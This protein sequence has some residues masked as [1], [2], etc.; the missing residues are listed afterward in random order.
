VPHP[1][2][3]LDWNRLLNGQ[4]PMVQA[5][6]PAQA[7][8]TTQAAP[9]QSL[10]ARV[11]NLFKSFFGTQQLS[12]QQDFFELGGDSLKAM[13]LLGRIK[14]VFE[15]EMTLPQFF[16]NTQLESLYRHIE[17][18]SAP[19]IQ[20][21]T[22]AATQSSYPLTPAQQHMWLLC[23]EPQANVAYNL[24]AVYTL[25][26][27]VQLPLLQQALQ[28]VVQRHEV[29]RTI[30]RA[31]E[32][33]EDAVRQVVL[34]KPT[35]KVQVLKPGSQTTAQT[36]QAF[37]TQP[38]DLAQG[39]LIRL[40][41]L[42]NGPEQHLVLLCAHHLVSDGQSIE[43]IQQELIQAYQA[44]QQK[45]P[46]DLAPLPLQFK[47]YAT[48]LHHAL[49]EK[50]RLQQAKN[51]WTQQFEQPVPALNLVTDHPRPALNTYQGSFVNHY[52][53]AA[54]VP[55][56]KQL[57][58]EQGVSMFMGLMAATYTLLYKYTGQTDVVI[59]SP[60]TG[61]S[62]P[63][64]Q[65]QVGYYV[66]MLPVRA[67]VAPHQP[68][69]QLLQQVKQAC[70][71]A[72]A[73]QDFPLESLMAQLAQQHEGQRNTL[74][75]ISLL[76]N[77]TAQDPTPV[78]HA[79][80]D[81]QQA[82]TT[83]KF[84]L[85]FN[86]IEG[87][88]S[89]QIQLE[90]STD[91][92]ERQTVQMLAQHLAYLLQQ[93]PQQQQQSPQDISLVSKEEQHQLLHTF[94]N[95]TEQYPAKSSIAAQFEAQA[96]S[97]PNATALTFEQ[98]SLSYQQL[99]AQA[100]QLAAC[101]LQQHQLKKG[102]AVAI[103]LERG[104]SLIV[105]T[106]A[107]LKAG[108][109]YVPIDTAHPTQRQ[110][111]LLQNSGAVLHINAAFYQAFA[112]QQEQWPS[113]NPKVQVHGQDLA[114]IMYTSGS[115]GN[116]KGVMVEQHSVL[117]LVKGQNYMPLN[118]STTLLSTGAVAFDAVVF[119]YWG[120]LLNG[121]HLIMCTAEAL[122][123]P[124]WL[125]QLVQQHQVNTFWLTTG[126]LN[127]LTESVPELFKG[128]Q[129]LIF[130]GER[131]SAPHVH[132]L[133]EL[134]PEM[135][136]IQAYGPTENT[137]Y[138]HTCRLLPH[139]GQRLPLGQPISNTTAY[140]LDA[141]DRLQPIGVPGQICLGGAGL[142]RGYLNQPALTQK[143]FVP[144]PFAPG[145]KM[146][147]TGDV[148]RM[149]PNGQLLFIGRKDNQIK[150]RGHRIELGEIERVLEQH[151]QV[152]QNVVLAQSLPQK[153]H[154]TLVAYVALQ[155]N[156]N[157]QPQELQSYLANALPAYMVPEHVL[158]LPKL[159]LNQNGKINRKALPPVQEQTPQQEA[160]TAPETTTQ[161][162]L[163]ALWAQVL[164]INPQ[165]VGQSQ[166][167]FDLGGHSLSVLRLISLIQKE[168]QL[169]LSVKSIFENPTLA[170]QAQHLD[171]QQAQ[172]F[173]QIPVAPT[174][175]SYVLSAAQQRLWVLCQFEQANAA[176]NIPSLHLLQGK[177]NT[178]AL[179]QAFK[180]LIDRHA[181]L[182]TVFKEVQPE[183]VHQVVQAQ[184][185]FALHQQDL[186]QQ[187]PTQAQNT[188]NGFA[189]QPFNLA[190][191]P[192]LR[193]GLFK[194]APQK[195]VLVIVLHHI[196][197]DGASMQVFFK[198]LMHLYNGHEPLPPLRIQYHDYAVW[199]QQQGQQGALQQAKA[200][201]LEQFA[202]PLPVLEIPANKPRP[203]VKTYQGGTVQL[204]LNAKAVQ[205]LKA[206]CQ[207][208]EAT[209]FMGLYALTN[210]LLYRYSGQTD[211]VLGS[212]VAG[213]EHVDLQE[214]I[215]FYV[216]MLPLRL[217]LEQEQSFE[218]VLAQARQVLLN[219]Y[220]HQSYPFDALVQA[221]DPP[222]NPSRSPLF[223]VM[224]TFQ[225][226]E[227]TPAQ[228]ATG[229]LQATPY[230]QAFEYQVSKYDLVFNYAHNGQQVGLGL[231]YNSNLFNRATI[232]HMATHLEQLL[233]SLAKQPAQSIAAAN[234]LTPPQRQE[235]LQDFNNTQ[236]PF[237]HHK[238]LVHRF[239][240]QAA[241]R[242]NATALVQ[243]SQ[244][245]TFAQVQQQ[246]NQLAHYLMQEKQV[247][248]NTYVGVQLETS[249]NRVVAL[250][251]V[252]KC[253]AA[254]VPLA[255]G[256]PQSRLDFMQQDCG[257]QVLIDANFMQQFEQVQNLFDTQSP[258][259]PIGPE[260]TA[261]AIYT[262]GST[263]KPKGVPIHHQ[264]VVNRIEWMWQA[265]Q[266]D[267]H[268]VVLQ[269]TTYTFDV[270]VWELF[271]PLG[272]GCTMALC[273]PHDA[274]SPERILQRM[275]QH[276][277]TCLH[278]VPS[279][280]KAFVS[281][282][283]SQH[284]EQMAT[285]RCV[286]TSGEALP[287]DLVQQWYQH[288]QA[289]VYNLYGPTEAAID[290]S[291]YNTQ[292]QDQQV[293]IGR[294]IANTQLYILSPAAQLQPI[295]AVGEIGI[296]G[297]GLSKG[298]LN[299]PAL[300]KERFIQ[301][302]F[303]PGQQLYR[304]GDLGRWL[305]NGNIE[306][307]GRIDD[308]VKIRGFRIEPGEVA[309]ALNQFEGLA[310]CAVAAQTLQNE[311]VLVAYAVLQPGH[312]WQ[313]RAY[314]THL[315][316]LLPAYMVPA[317]FVQLEQLP[318]T[319]NGKLNKKALP[320]PT[321]TSAARQTPYVAPQNQ[322]EQQIVA[323][324]AQVLKLPEPQIGSQHNFFELGGH[325]LKAINLVGKLKKQLG[326]QA[327]IKDVFEHPTV[328]A[329]AR[330]LAGKP[331]VQQGS[332]PK[333]PA[334]SKYPLSS[335]QRRLWVLSQ[336]PGAS[337]AYNMPGIHTLQGPL[338]IQALQQ[339]FGQLVARH[340]AL[341]TT[342]NTTQ[343]SQ[344]WQYVQAPAPFELQTVNAQ[345]IPEQELQ[346]QLA[347]FV[348][349]PFN[350]AQGPLLRAAV[351]TLAPNRHL[352]AYVLH[353]IVGDAHS[354]QVLFAELMALYVAQLE[355]QPAN[356]PPLNVQY[357]DYAVW[358]QNAL[359]QAQLQ[360]AK[361]YWLQKMQGPLPLLELPH[362]HPRP[363]ERT[364]SGGLE[365]STIA[366]AHA[367]GL[368]QLANQHGATP[369][370]ALAALVK[371]L[372]YRYT[373][374]QDI[375][376]GTPIAGREHPDLQSQIGFFVNT[377][378][379]R[380]QLQGSQTFEQVLQNVKNTALEA[381]AHQ[382]YPFD[383]LVDQLALP[384]N[385][386]RHPLFDVLLTY[387]Q[388]AN[389]PAHKDLLAQTQLQVLPN[390]TAPQQV[391]SKFDLSFHFTQAGQKLHL[392]IEYST[393]LFA[394]ATMQR[395]LQ[396]LTQ[397]LQ[398]IVAQP[399]Q[400]IQKLRLLPQQEE[401]QVVH[402]FN[403]TSA[404]WPS[405]QNIVQLFEQQAA[406]SPQQVALVFE[407]QQLSY[408]Q[409]NQL[410]NR[411]AA[412]LAQQH[413]VQPG[414]R[415]GVQLHR[416]PQLIVSLLAVLK[417]GAAVVPLDPAYPKTRLDFML[418]DSK[419]QVLINHELLQ[420]FEQQ[421]QS[422]SAQ[423]PEPQASPNALAYLIYTSGSTGTPKG[424]MVEHQ[425]V[426]RLVKGHNYVP[427]NAQTNLLA[428]V[429]VAFDVSLFEY[430]GPLLN[431][432]KLLLCPHEQLLDGN[433]L[434]GLIKQHSINT[435]WLTAGLMTTMVDTA[436]HMFE[437]LK[438][439]MAG[440]DALSAQHIATLQQRYPKLQIIN[441]YGPTENTSFSTTC[442]LT[443]QMQPHVP[444]GKPINNST[445]YV[446]DEHLQPQP[447]G[448]VGHIY[449][450]GAGLARGYWQNAELTRQRFVPNP[451]APGQR[452]YNTGDLGSWQPNGLLR[453]HGRADTQV[454]ISGHRI[455]LAEVQN[456]IEAHPQVKS[457][458][459]VV[460]SAAASAGATTAASAGATAGASVGATAATKQLVA[461]VVAPK[462]LE[463]Q[464]LKAFVA[465]Q[466]PAYMVPAYIEHLEALPLNPNGK[467]NT[468]ALPPPQS[469]NTNLKQDYAAPENHLQ[470]R[471]THIWGNLLELPPQEVS[472]TA[473][474]FDIGGNSLKIVRLKDALE[475]QLGHNVDVGTLFRFP[476]IKTFA[477]SIET[478]APAQVQESLLD[479][480]LDT[481]TENLSLLNNHDSE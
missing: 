88:Q 217:Q 278:F 266:F 86:F 46:L 310:Q 293:P 200:Y 369:F 381:F 110:E 267:H 308:Q 272:W 333:A 22:P 348:Q 468:K 120:T 470:E 106:L 412:C 250:M 472:V 360:K 201:W 347:A 95:T 291:Y 100:N 405:Q 343:N 339:A 70:L 481:F 133:L 159:P 117:R 144:N 51:Y 187:D 179:E 356:L 464:A 89:L 252:L 311:M 438:Y 362:D 75:D 327:D 358:Q 372:L 122:L 38:F 130:G 462:S 123:T 317:H 221:L 92:F 436:P 292:P 228:A 389:D 479:N 473:N 19:Q 264:A 146:Y 443:P 419:C 90:Y 318:L 137:T 9:H 29:L 256:A 126:L 219:A 262:S 99:N 232:E 421:Q 183:Q 34:P 37:L 194:L 282:L 230:H 149:L 10:K 330:H 295:G 141:Q 192:L 17:K 313:P 338:N 245:L 427:L 423:N 42:P 444:I 23:Q 4:S 281:T 350:L 145:Q 402:N 457:C 211:L 69:V 270:S 127:S 441:G 461:Y 254:Y 445:A 302:P 341:R 420:Q 152:A 6:T 185:P 418:Q 169:K 390:E 218:Q 128:I 12:L 251:A 386:G 271:M 451:F 351:F 82:Y 408:E 430:Y 96:A 373:A 478:A 371:V 241:A 375:I 74:F 416:G 446:L 62:Q 36:I 138:S 43:I 312:E 198:E 223:D 111:Y 226:Q 460:S 50:G 424:V 41:L 471:L 364:F 322:L 258:Q 380:S 30:F 135:H 184:V 426:V 395:M 387:Q 397:L 377:L 401:Q 134:Y 428:T 193:A 154:K 65:G 172:G 216:N 25:H 165:Q 116:P 233:L 80:Q 284:Q 132:K 115:T 384:R 202:G 340:D 58:K 299:R 399:A 53:P 136:L 157:A 166:N 81:L 382:A 76:H 265:Y 259:V 197:A 21:I 454:K 215:G 289:P 335:S 326:L 13:T 331:L 324:W 207:Q 432:G 31:D 212:P 316:N 477:Q 1:V 199:Q 140:V 374:Q 455:E 188:M 298:Y 328:A 14:E 314:A 72:F 273:Q 167:F 307:L 28:Q 124:H 60:I 44:L 379:L 234:M 55:A 465:Q 20:S 208:Q 236:T 248:P 240:E 434:A 283:T 440:G 98:Q 383:E 306:Y 463:A 85:T 195:Q 320:L 150:L 178:S 203:A 425:S 148:G 276:K 452:L 155:A 175:Q 448:V 467:V 260:T 400:P 406:Q 214:Q 171:Q 476:T 279:M 253:G 268:D 3:N 59:G 404:P 422:F 107:V 363:Q 431:G 229:Q 300:N 67:Q 213:R 345:N 398:S 285:L 346:S 396:H 56:L 47:D 84:D 224:I 147:R 18:H 68:F 125:S 355:Q 39:P 337:V 139:M 104:I 437:H 156:E 57:F 174:A 182:R 131:V 357:N 439:L 49:Q 344:V 249:F 220:Q 474:F 161:K 186:S 177:L 142:A 287:A 411:L 87:P 466:L 48:W 246:A 94:N 403:Q 370:M 378:A 61:R 103:G 296:A 8:P 173:E 414:H 456:A 342:F 239:D 323:L 227:G 237:A 415:V 388:E 359:G 210:A 450:G 108:G 114:Y 143:H 231:E 54:H 480:A 329:Q 162:R 170:A 225:Q 222:R 394:P 64:L 121:G 24:S 27:Q 257:W 118:A 274:Q 168:W 35:L 290:V 158:L 409:L 244:Q 151:P 453:F 238:T 204:N 164:Q 435:M 280:L 113:T 433:A 91:L 286:I 2:N 269:K 15:V 97:T 180:G 407:Q 447:I 352:F 458:A 376:V 247:Q 349:K 315:E 365:Y 243:G 205:A 255:P 129:Y 7:Q 190:T 11:L 469:Q 391:A 189:S 475:K 361:N 305:P 321:G 393:D 66:N 242:P 33:F 93:L 71:Q 442:V 294:P 459:V 40:G 303:T 332:I 319:A 334:A 309:A 235:L 336:F 160:F 261:Y 263:G 109:V 63:A 78:A 112:A 52:L 181:A 277:V 417:A 191:A 77:T 26:Q 101:L 325:S 366:A 449:V 79:D 368:M 196:V 297:T 32:A 429:P 105:A 304:S 73:H 288:H 353:H 163:A 16:E 392:G 45:Q 83:S 5:T 413:Q 119:E 354:L 209:L 176:Y 275:A 206:L 385:T 301:N 102:Q 410:A 367:Q 153:A